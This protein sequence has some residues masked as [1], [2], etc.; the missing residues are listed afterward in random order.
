LAIGGRRRQFF[1]CE[2]HL[3]K[4][5]RGEERTGVG[6]TKGRGGGVLKL[7]IVKKLGMEIFVEMRRGRGGKS[8]ELQLKSSMGVAIIHEM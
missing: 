5:I 7:S 8:G 3:K 4:K 6:E 1:K 2:T